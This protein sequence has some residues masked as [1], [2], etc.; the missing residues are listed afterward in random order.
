M[1]KHTLTPIL[2][3]IKEVLKP[4][5]LTNAKKTAEGPASAKKLTKGEDPSQKKMRKTVGKPPSENLPNMDTKEDI[6]VGQMVPKVEDLT[7]Y[8]LLDDEIL[9]EY[10]P[11]GTNI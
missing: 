5:A 3:E 7:T 9:I 11:D 6:W 4:K 1:K 2:E 8:P 10:A